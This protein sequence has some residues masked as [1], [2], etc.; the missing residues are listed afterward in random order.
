MSGVGISI[1]PDIGIGDKMQFTSLPENYFRATGEKLIDVSKS[2]V[3]DHNPFVQRDVEASKVTELWNF[4][5]KQYEWPK[6]RPAPSVYTSNA[7]IWASLFGAK[8][9]LNRP[10]LYRFENVPFEERDYILL[11]THGR[12][13]GTMPDHI[14]DHVINKYK[15]TRKLYHVGLPSDPSYGLPKIATPTLW[16]LASLISRAR[17]F[18]GVDSGP[19]WVAAAYPDVVIKKVRLKTVHGEK[20]LS[21]WVPLEMD[22]IHSHWDDRL[23]QIYNA[24]EDDVTFTASYKKI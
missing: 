5:P 21:E 23:F 6:P 8:T 15:P 7:E 22:N 12:S 2:W 14:V 17:M 16:D 1:R 3:F 9:I 10:R 13:H 24:S 20:P 11:H 4:G 18:I 19:S